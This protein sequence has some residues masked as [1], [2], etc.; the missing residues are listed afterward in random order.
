MSEL[1]N[2]LLILALFL[3]AGLSYLMYNLSVIIKNQITTSI[4]NHKSLMDSILDASAPKTRTSSKNRKDAADDPS[5]QRKPGIV[6]KHLVKDRQLDF[7]DDMLG[8]AKKMEVLVN[9]I[10]DNLNT[11]WFVVLDVKNRK[12]VVTS[13][14]YVVNHVPIDTKSNAEGVCR[15]LNKIYYK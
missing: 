7:M 2:Y 10:S 11:Y 6:L 13:S 15:E 9:P 5:I 8:I 1:T 3:L 4:S 12:L 14:K